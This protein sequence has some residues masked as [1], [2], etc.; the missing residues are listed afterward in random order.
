[1]E[2]LITITQTKVS[3]VKVAFKIP[4]DQNFSLQCVFHSIG[5]STDSRGRVKLKLVKIPNSVPEVWTTFQEIHSIRDLQLFHSLSNRF[6]RILFGCIHRSQQEKP[7]EINLKKR[8]QSKASEVCHSDIH[9]SV[10]KNWNLLVKRDK[11]RSKKSIDILVLFR[12]KFYSDSVL[13][14]EKTQLNHTTSGHP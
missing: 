6:F 2:I 14:P 3:L 13:N 7:A 5:L 11:K 1:M 9:I 12:L 8:T 4:N 10:N